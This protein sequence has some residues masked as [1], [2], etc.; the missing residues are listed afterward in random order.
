MAHIEPPTLET[1][2]TRLRPFRRSDIADRAALGDDPD[3]IRMFGGTPTADTPQPLTLPAAEAWFAEVTADNG[4][5]HW[6]VEYAGRFIGTAR[7]HAI[8]PADRRARYAIGILDPDGLGLGLGTEITL[9][10]LQHGFEV[11]NLHRIDLRVLEY[12]HRA[13]RCYRR[14]GF[15]EEGRERDAALVGGRWYDDVMMSIL[16]HEWRPMR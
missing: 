1:P 9:A 8:V 13:I 5:T 10:V 15:V 4:A 14:C 7:L 16:E 6:A 12:N 3:I 2:R 11:V